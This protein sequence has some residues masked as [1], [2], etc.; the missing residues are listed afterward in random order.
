MIKWFKGLIIVGMSVFLSGVLSAGEI[1]VE[2]RF[3]Q[4]F[5]E[6]GNSTLTIAS[7]YSLKKISDDKIIPFVELDKEPRQLKE[8]Y[9]LK[10]VKRLG[11]LNIMLGKDKAEGGS[12]EVM[13]DI[14]LNGQTLI[15]RVYTAAGQKDRFGI[16]ILE[17]GE[18][19]RVLLESEVIVPDGKTA[20]LGFKDSGEKIYFLAFNRKYREKEETLAEL[21]IAKSIKSPKLLKKKEPEY[22]PLALKGGIEGEVVLEGQTDL[23]GNVTEVNILE[24]HPLLAKAAQEVLK[25]WKYAVWEVDGNKKPVSFSM[26]LIFRIKR[27]PARGENEA[28]KILERYRPLL[29]EKE[30]KTKKSLPRILEMVITFGEKA[31]P[32]DEKKSQWAEK[33]GAKS[34]ETPKLIRR[35]DPKY[36]AAAL[37]ANIEGDVILSGKTD[38]D[39][40]VT[41]IKVRLGHPLLSGAAVNAARQWKYLPWKIDGTA[42]PVEFTLVIIYRTKKILSDK[43]NPMVKEVLDR[44]KQLLEKG[45]EKD[46]KIPALMEVVLIEGK[47]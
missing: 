45:R 44:N 9:K 2:L 5:Y 3:Y 33:I 23:E 41:D 38:T 34:I 46:K 27:D 24:G 43:I 25:H 32:E 10:D 13:T 7:S 21:L 26:I 11:S 18:K 37:D 4:G 22:P 39:G 17:K 29:K 35:V 16:E 47:K 30:P 14:R 15:L 12:R 1:A 36:P 6:S 42:K 40:N 8:V 19:E 20:V 31:Q 28:E